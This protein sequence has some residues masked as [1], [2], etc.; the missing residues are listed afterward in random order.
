[1]LTWTKG[2]GTDSPDWWEVLQGDMKG[3]EAQSSLAEAQTVDS[4]DTLGFVSSQ[5]YPSIPQAVP[6]P[7]DSCTILRVLQLDT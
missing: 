3:K 7:G 4:V 5:D 2:D 1:M 6:T